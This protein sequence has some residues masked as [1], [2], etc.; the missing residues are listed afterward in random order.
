MIKIVKLICCTIIL[1]VSFNTRA[2]RTAFLNDS[3]K[4][5]IEA[6]P[7]ES[8]P[9]IDSIR[10]NLNLNDDELIYLYYQIGDAYYLQSKRDTSIFFLSKV[11]SSPNM[12]PENPIYSIALFKLAAQYRI[13]KPDT[14][15]KDLIL[16]SKN[17]AIKYNHEIELARILFG[18]AF[19]L[20]RELKLDSAIVYFTKASNIYLKYNDSLKIGS[21]YNSIGIIM[22]R[23]SRTNRSIYFFK[24]AIK[25]FKKIENKKHLI[26]AYGNLGG[27]F[28]E[29]DQIDSSLFYLNKCQEIV[30][31]NPNTRL[32]N[33]IMNNLASIYERKENLDTA[34][35]YYQLALNQKSNNLNLILTFQGNILWIHTKRKEFQKG[36]VLIDTILTNLKS[37]SNLQIRLNTYSKLF[38]FYYDQGKLNQ[39]IEYLREYSSL[40]EQ[41]FDIEKNKI[42]NELDAKYE[43]SRKEKELQLIKK[44]KNLQEVQLE[45]EATKNG[46][47]QVLIIISIISLVL[48]SIALYQGKQ[49]LIA[50]QK[51]NTQQEELSKKSLFSLEQTKKIETLS[52]K[53]DGQ[54]QERKRIAQELHDN[55]GSLLST[56]KYYYASLQPE[57]S[58]F[59]FESPKIKKIHNF[60]DEACNEVRKVAHTLH[61]D[62]HYGHN[63]DYKIKE[64]V[65]R[66]KDSDDMEAE[67]YAHGVESLNLSPF[68]EKEIYH[69]TSELVNNVIKHANARHLVISL[70]FANH[71]LTIIIE[72]DG[73]GIENVDISNGMGWK[74]IQE[75]T[76]SMN[77]SFNIDSRLEQGTTAVLEFKN[78]M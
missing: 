32:S 54:E 27:V 38:Y 65:N 78:L 31:N 23:F 15:W 67:Y 48:F 70:T 16:H 45:Q 12:N 8:I 13:V 4:K 40:Q 52:A 3:I 61:D 24:K 57:L 63:L 47:Y 53:M 50:Q 34:L 22:Q 19:N 29:N 69:M 68:E 77:G 9:L 6:K 72:D 46:F 71:E 7:I 59:G 11:L 60:I 39:A 26:Y 62:G 66:L 5:I 21:C 14:N 49:K 76:Q 36:S 74:T 20:K 42:V 58:K 18:Q 75:R 73:K 1:F 10:N 64:L 56:V 33:S 51:L 44:E 2:N 41:L 37:V 43:I 30:D 28:S 35:Y 55:L 25:Y 17:N